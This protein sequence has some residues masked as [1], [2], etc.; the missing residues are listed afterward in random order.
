ETSSSRRRDLVEVAPVTPVKKITF[1]ASSLDTPSP[2]PRPARSLPKPSSPSPA[3]HA[4]LSAQET[5]QSMEEVSGAYGEEEGSADVEEEE[6]SEFVLKPVIRPVSWNEYQLIKDKLQQT[7][8]EKSQL[9][10]QFNS[11]SGM[12]SLLIGILFP[13]FNHT[14]TLLFT[15]IYSYK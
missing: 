7:M 14:Y 6:D 8:I 2:T 5:K 3:K 4:F 15:F 11:V 1:S 13:R 10:G 9:E 12:V